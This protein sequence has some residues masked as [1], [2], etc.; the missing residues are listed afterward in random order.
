MTRDSICG[1]MMDPCC[2]EY[3]YDCYCDACYSFDD[4]C[5]IAYYRERECMSDDEKKAQEA[6]IC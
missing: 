1:I 3:Y 2:N 4:P 6:K 5:E